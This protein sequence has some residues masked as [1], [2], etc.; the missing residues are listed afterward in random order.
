MFTGLVERIGAWGGLRRAGDN[1]ELEIAL[2]KPWDDPL[3]IGESIAVQGAC[4]TVVKDDG[5]RFVC[6]LLEETL[7]RTNFAN[8]ENGDIL[9]LERAV[10]AGDRLGGHLVQGHV[11]GVGKVIRVGDDRGDRSVRI[12]CDEGLMAGMIPKGSIAC[13]GISLT[14]AALSDAGFQVNII[15][16]TWSETSLRTLATG[17]T[18]NIETDLIGKYVLRNSPP[19]G[20]RNINMQMLG[21]AG[22]C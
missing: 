3:V 12:A 19:S 7:R 1:W 22:F 21:D 17:A 5:D 4:L 10:R 11:D 14:I 9:N 6:N 8:K 20:G 16:H 2:L 13:D 15:P 18:V